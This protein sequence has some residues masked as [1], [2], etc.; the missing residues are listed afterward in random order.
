LLEDLAENAEMH[1]LLERILQTLAE[2]FY[3]DGHRIVITASLG[4]TVYPRDDSDA[5]TLMRHAD[6]AMYVA[7]QTGRNRFHRFD[8]QKDRQI[9]S[10]HQTL[11]RVRSAV[12][13]G[14]LRLHYQPKLN[15]RTSA[16]QGFE[17]LLRWQHPQDGMIPPLSFLPMVEQSDVIVDIGEWVIEQALTQLAQWAAMGTVWPVSVNIAARHFQCDDFLPRLQAILARHPEVSPALLEFEILESVAL[18]DM[19]AMNALIANC[20]TLGIG[21]SLDD[22]GTGYS[23]LSY[24]KRIPVQTLKIDQSFVRDMLDDHD[25]LALVES[26]IKIAKL[27]R[28][29][30]I[31]EGVETVD[32]GVLLLRLGCSVAQGYGIARPMPPEQ[33]PQWVADYRPDTLWRAWADLKWDFKDLPLLVAQRDHAEWVQRVIDSLQLP[34][35]AFAS[36]SSDETHVCRFGAW[37]EGHGKI[38][39]GH[40]VAFVVMESR[41]ARLHTLGRSLLDAHAQGQSDLVQALCTDLMACNEQLSLLLDDIHR[42]VWRTLAV[43][44]EPDSVTS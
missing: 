38:K 19:T 2:P 26:V 39:Y 18:G 25:D 13:L 37:L 43:A 23:S 33:V 28:L 15:L 27:F 6:Q 8:V 5:D 44:N 20:R 31:A 16:I 22:F 7:K 40:L 9:E 29:D 3:I 34:T 1:G 32:Q 11:E 41:H 17:A 14:E 4:L 21:F 35:P 10:N 30:V 36:G 24:L 12:T 42:V